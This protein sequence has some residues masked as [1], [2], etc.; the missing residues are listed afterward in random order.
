MELPKQR[1]TAS[2][3][4]K[5]LKLPTIQERDKWGWKNLVFLVLMALEEG[6]FFVVTHPNRLGKHYVDK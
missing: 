6:N 4:C 3:E 2:P 5:K 1:L